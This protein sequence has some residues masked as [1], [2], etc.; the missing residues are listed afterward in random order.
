MNKYYT[1][2]EILQVSE[3]FSLQNISSGLYKVLQEVEDGLEKMAL[4]NYLILTE[5]GLFKDDLLTYYSRYYWFMTF[6]ERKKSNSGDD[7]GLDQQLFKI[8]EESESF[9]EEVDWSVIQEIE[10]EVKK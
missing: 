10:K 6:V 5:S 2:E 4:T 3:G 1:Q 8:I 7:A 9:A